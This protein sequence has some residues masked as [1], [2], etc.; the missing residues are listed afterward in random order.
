MWCIQP[1]G[2][3]TTSSASRSRMSHISILRLKKDDTA[4]VL[5]Q[6][7]VELLPLHLSDAIKHIVVMYSRKTGFPSHAIIETTSERISMQIIEHL[8]YRIGRYELVLGEAKVA[9][10][11][12]LGSI[13]MSMMV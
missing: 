6:K 2:Y 8:F 11:T 9:T 7:L 3:V 1:R 10:Q 4:R 13:S 12:R 5:M